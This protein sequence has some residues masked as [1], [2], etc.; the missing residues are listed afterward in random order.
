ME[1]NPH[2]NVI[3]LCLQGMAMKKRAALMRQAGY[4]FRP[5]GINERLE[6]FTAAHYVLGIKKK[7]P[8]D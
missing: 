1:F 5:G 6:K 8:T 3:K 4:F 7:F 2:N